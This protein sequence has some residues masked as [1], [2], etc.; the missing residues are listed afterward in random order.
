MKI[1]RFIYLIALTALFITPVVAQN[2]NADAVYQ[3][4]VK[5]YTLKPDGSTVYRLQKQIKLLSQ[6]SFNRL[7]GETFIVYNPQYQKLSINKAFTVT[8]TAKR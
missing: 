1:F 4:L 8:A 5:E 6:L 2:E 7:Y 3:K